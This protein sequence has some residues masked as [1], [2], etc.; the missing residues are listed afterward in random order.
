[1]D[2]VQE[3]AEQLM[4]AD[5][6]TDTD[7]SISMKGFAKIDYYFYFVKNATAFDERIKDTLVFAYNSER[8]SA[9]KP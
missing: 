2:D 7:Q 9:E 8:L 5:V 4:I 6:F 1:L 3:A